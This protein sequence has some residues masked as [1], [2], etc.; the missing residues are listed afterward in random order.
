MENI[1][2][3]TSIALRGDVLSQLSTQMRETPSATRRGIENA[4]PISVAALAQH[5]SSDQKAE[6]LLGTLRGGSYPHVDPSNVTQMVSD[7]EATSRLSQSGK[8]FL[9]RIFGTRLNSVIDALAGQAGLSRDSA[10]TLLGFATPLVLNAVGKEAET[11]NLDARGL[12]RFLQDQGRRAAGV[13]PGPLASM[14]APRAAGVGATAAGTG[15][16]IS[17]AADRARSRASEAMHR[18]GH[19]GEARQAPSRKNIWWA[20]LGIG[21]LALLALSLFGRRDRAAETVP[22]IDARGGAIPDTTAP[23]T[24]RPGGMEQPQQAQ[25]QQPAQPQAQQPAQQQQAQAPAEPGGARP[26]AAGQVLS[27]AT[28][29]AALTTALTGDASLPQRFELQGV[30][31]P[32]GSAAVP[33][34][35]MLDEVAASLTEHDSARVR[36]EGFADPTGPAEM[37]QELSESRAESVKNYLVSKGVD[38]NRIETVG[39]GAQPQGAAQGGEAAE[40]RVD[41]VVLAR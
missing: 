30:E 41:L 38:A 35:P 24:D 34:N 40:R 32:T 25:P 10:S 37:N 23:G 15:H 20:I 2:D 8:G 22:D 27:P 3:I 26:G 19:A 9:G 33:S 17:D 28:G 39:R 1:L 11:R 4:V 12:S 6:E 5:A 36:L 21:L 29:A 16:G 31:F 14:M 18:V 7:P 13:L